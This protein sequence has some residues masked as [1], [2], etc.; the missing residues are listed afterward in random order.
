MN[1]LERPTSGQIIFDGIDITDTKQTLISASAYGMV[2]QHFNL[3]PHKT[4]MEIITLAPVRLKLMKPEE[5]KKK[6]L[7]FLN[8]LT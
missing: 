4:I 3:F 7:D 6:L 1:L 8:W 2:F 5:A